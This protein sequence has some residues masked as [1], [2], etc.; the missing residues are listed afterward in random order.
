MGTKKTTEEFIEEVSV[1]YPEIRVISEYI[2]AHT[3]VTLGC[4][5][6][7]TWLASPTNLLSKGTRSK[8]RECKGKNNVRIDWTSYNI[9]K[10]KELASIGYTTEEL[11]E[12]FKTTKVS[13]DNACSDN[14]II[15]DRFE[16]GGKKAL[17]Q[18]CNEIGYSITK[19][20][21]SVKGLF[22]YICNNGHAHTQIVGNFMRGHLCPKCN[23][24]TGISKVETELVDFIKSIYPGWVELKDRSILEGK[25][26][27]IVLPDLGVAFEFNGTYWHQE[28]KVGKYYHQE[29]TQNTYNFGYQL[30][31]IY[32]YLWESKK[33][34]VKSRIRG[35]LK[36]NNKIYARNCI[37]KSIQFPKEFLNINHLQGS[38]SPSS[39]NYGLFFKEELVAVMTF[40]K[41]R[42]STQCDYELIR[43]CSLLDINI[44]G[45][46]SKLLKAFTREHPGS[47]IS[48]SDKSWS[49][50]DLYTK[51]GFMYS[52]TTQPNYR[53]FKRYESLTRYEC[54]KHLLKV[55]FPT[56]Y[57]DELTEKEI[58]ALEGYY[59]VYDSGNDVW[60]LGGECVQSVA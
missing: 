18:R 23:S 49:I 45:G 8:C 16:M 52:H 60:V 10:L 41:P 46:A 11:M 40:S 55:K 22:S 47:I 29:K 13:I 35:I 3:N 53:Y 12:E 6:G 19:M 43:Y 54:Q 25:E 39:F 42:F 34:I 27:D 36:L 37:V 50:G 58:M 14:S 28:D 2:D 59:R 15:R 30:I 9:T 31:H 21:L 51:L 26:L 33:D 17:I 1:K 5:N 48:Y 7:H 44:I 20:A 24:A 38:G 32:D 56:S 4:V 57:K